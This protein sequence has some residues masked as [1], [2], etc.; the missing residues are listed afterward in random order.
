MDCLS[1]KMLAVLSLSLLATSILSTS[2]DYE[3]YKFIRDYSKQYSSEE[4]FVLRRNIFTNNL[5][6]IQ[7]H[8]HHKEERGLT[9]SLE[10]NHLADVSN[11]EY[12]SSLGY[13]SN[14]RRLSEIEM[15]LPEIESLPLSIDWRSQHAVTN[16][17]AY[18]PRWEIGS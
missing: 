18:M 2:V 15:D 13:R 5:K 10:I 3:F 11:E 7:D 9:Y 4:E 1:I 6:Y 16:V 12:S 14:I 8:N 17:V